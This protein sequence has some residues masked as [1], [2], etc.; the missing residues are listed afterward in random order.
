MAIVERNKQSN[1]K[2]NSEQEKIKWRILINSILTEK[3]GVLTISDI[4]SSDLENLGSIEKINFYE[5]D[6]IGK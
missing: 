2:N 3:D 4:T 5:F 1:L 6:T